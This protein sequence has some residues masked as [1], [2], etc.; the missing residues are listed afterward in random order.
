MTHRT[1]RVWLPGNYARCTPSQPCPRKPNCARYMAALPPHGAVMADY[2]LTCT[3]FW[4]PGYIHLGLAAALE[5]GER[6]AGKG[7]KTV[8][9]APEGI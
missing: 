5:E 4:C 1:D 8:R 6:Q 3:S 7:G 9:P 2:S